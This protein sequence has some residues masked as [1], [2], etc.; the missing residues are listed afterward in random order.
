MI[1]LSDLVAKGRELEVQRLAH[2]VVG[3]GQ[4][5][6]PQRFGSLGHHLHLRKAPRRRFHGTI[7]RKPVGGVGDVPF[8]LVVVGDRMVVSNRPVF[9]YSTHN[10]IELGGRAMSVVGVATGEGH[11][12]H[13]CWTF[14]GHQ[15]T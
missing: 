9:E 10:N 11:D 6:D 3:V 7:A 4:E 8:L 14:V 5:E 13:C 2:A 12:A 1:S 15:A